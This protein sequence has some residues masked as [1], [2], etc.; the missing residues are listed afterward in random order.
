MYSIPQ[1]HL[2]ALELLGNDMV[3]DIGFSPIRI[4]K[5]SSYSLVIGSDGETLKVTSDDLGSHG[6]SFPFP[7]P[8]SCGAIIS[9]RW[10]G[11]WANVGIRKAFMGSFPLYE[12]W[13]DA[14]EQTGKEEDVKS[15][16][17]S[18]TAIWTRELQ[19]EPIVM[20]NVGENLV[21]SCLR[22]GIYMI[23]SE[24]R[25]IWRSPYPIWRELEL[26]LIHI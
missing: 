16:Y 17:I 22:T 9:D 8:S 18:N 25:E 11:S 3:D 13:A 15:P 7:G 12:K 6:I 21:F 14:D 23:D 1:P 5:G 20:C 4:D 26:S 24:A 19:S 2:Q 10:I